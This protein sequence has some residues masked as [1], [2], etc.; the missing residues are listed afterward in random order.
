MAYTAIRIFLGLIFFTAGMSKIFAGHRF[1]GV[2]GPPWLA[3]RLAVYDLAFFAKFIAYAQVVIGFLLLTRSWATLGAVACVPMITCILMVTISLRWQ[4]T[5]Y[6]NTVLLGMNLYLLWR[7]REKFRGLVGQ[8]T[9]R[10][11]V[12]LAGVLAAP[13]LSFWNPWAGYG[14]VGVSLAVL[15]WRDAWRRQGEQ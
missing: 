7:D 9:V 13:A 15:Q 11:G 3:D 1:P 6:V 14:A 10:H 8:V 4:G 2:I 12:A 5:P